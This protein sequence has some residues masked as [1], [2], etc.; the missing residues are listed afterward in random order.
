MYK[1]DLALNNLQWLIYHKTKLKNIMFRLCCARD[2][3]VKHA[4][5]YCSKRHKRNTRVDTT[6]RES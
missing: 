5:R 4:A 3:I 2:E 6:I 1:Q